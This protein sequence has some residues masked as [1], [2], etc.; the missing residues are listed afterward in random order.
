MHKLAYYGN[1]LPE[2]PDTM[3]CQEQPLFQQGCLEKPWWQQHMR[4]AWPK[5]GPLLGTRN[6]ANHGAIRMVGNSKTMDPDTPAAAP[7]V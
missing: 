5:M 1:A 4:K 2:Q 3:A 6:R 7:Q